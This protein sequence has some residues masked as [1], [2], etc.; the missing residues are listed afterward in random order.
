MKRYRF[1]LDPVLRV[2]RSEQDAARAAVLAAQAVVAT[3][4]EHLA[5]RDAAYAHGTSASG[6]RSA[7]EFL[8]EQAH[9][10]ALAAA[11]LEQRRQVELAEQCARGA[12]TAWTAAAARVTAL[13]RLDEHQRA[14]HT[15]RAQREE[16]L[17]VDDLVVARFGRAER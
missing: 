16:E 4:L 9:A 10:G 7:A 5:R 14:E 11:L 12:R 2:R 8:Y 13:E 15:V 3:E 17:I 1:R 6:P